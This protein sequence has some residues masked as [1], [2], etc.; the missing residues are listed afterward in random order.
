MYKIT[1]TIGFPKNEF[2]HSSKK[3]SMY[4]VNEDSKF[5]IAYPI[6]LSKEVNPSIDV[7]FEKRLKSARFDL[8]EDDVINDFK[9][10]IEHILVIDPNDRYDSKQIANHNFFR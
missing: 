6:Q 5:K 1:Q 10:L 8:E 9:D 7:M 3:Y 4:F 2:I